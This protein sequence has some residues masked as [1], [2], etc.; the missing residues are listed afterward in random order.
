MELK[1][2]ARN[3]ELKKGWQMKIEEEKEKLLRHHAG[4]VLHLRV[5]IEAT[6]HHKQDNYEV[7][8]VA[9]VPNDTVV[10]SKKGDVVRALLVEAFDVLA[11]KLKE[12]TRKKR[13]LKKNLEQGGDGDGKG[14]VHLVVP[15]ES[16]GFITSVDQREIYFHENALKN[17]AI[18][19]LTEGD[20]VIFGESRG[21]KG[22]QAAWVRVAK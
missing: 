5:A 3:V 16:Y 15:S 21:D 10:V 13:K 14:V 2:E 22:P 4:F 9:S 7:K 19:S 8:I 17:V 18:S 6:T 11:L 12:I 20:L 1:I